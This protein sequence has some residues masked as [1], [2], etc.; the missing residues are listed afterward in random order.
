MS[1]SPG[2]SCHHQP[3]MGRQKIPTNHWLLRKTPAD[4][5]KNTSYQKNGNQEEGKQ[6]VIKPQRSASPVSTIIN[7]VLLPENI[8]DPLEGDY[9]LSKLFIQRLRWIS[10]PADARIR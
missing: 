10:A 8:L 2:C 9:C 4:E 1:C 3:S 6:L 7:R 5:T